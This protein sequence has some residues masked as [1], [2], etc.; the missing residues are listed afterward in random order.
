MV[1]GRYFRCKGV[2]WDK[3]FE[4]GVV[5]SFV[6]ELLSR[7][8]S[9]WTDMLGVGLVLKGDRCCVEASTVR[10]VETDERMLCE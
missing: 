3:G 10:G 7:D 1:S 4:R 8:Y 6:A 2:N 5:W 9:E